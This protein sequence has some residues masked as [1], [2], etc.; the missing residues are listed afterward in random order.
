M[1]L[2]ERL[3]KKLVRLRKDGMLKERGAELG[4]AF[5]DQVPKK[6]LNRSDYITENFKR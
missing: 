6:V 5:I 3:V 4:R 2:E 1:A